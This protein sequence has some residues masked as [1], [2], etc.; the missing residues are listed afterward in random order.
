MANWREIDPSAFQG[1]PFELIGKNWGL[2]TAEKNGKVNTM[3]ISWGFMGV[4][5]GK[6]VMAVVIRP[7]RFTKEF[8]DSA[9]TF[10][11]SFL[12]ESYRKQLAYLGK[13]SGRDED[14]IAKSE[15]QVA[16]IDETPYF[17]EA[18]LTIAARKLYAQPMQADLFIDKAQ[19]AQWYPEQDYHTLYIAEIEHILQKGE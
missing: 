10:S 1:N 11:V 15:L 17:D 6:N 8:V 19:D 14:K 13:V 16:H 3:T 4:M 2:L 7:Q 12:D 9:D 5:W 18:F